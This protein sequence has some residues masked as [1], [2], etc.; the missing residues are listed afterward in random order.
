MTPI[1]QLEE[2][3]IQLPPGDKIHLIQVLAQSL[4]EAWNPAPQPETETGEASSLLDFFRQSPL[5]E[6]IADSEELDLSRDQS[7]TPDR[8]VL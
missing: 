2:Q 7:L 4:H 6:A 8:F 3:L 1:S 5:A